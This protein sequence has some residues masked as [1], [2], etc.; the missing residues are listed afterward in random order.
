MSTARP[1]R[2]KE[3]TPAR[4]PLFESLETRLMMR[5]WGFSFLPNFVLPYTINGTQGN[6]YINVS[7]SNNAIL[8]PRM[9]VQINSSPAWIAFPA[10]GQAIQIHWQGRA[11]WIGRIVFCPATAKRLDLKGQ[12]REQ[13]DAR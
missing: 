8:G 6:D 10:V 7:Y 2:S 9:T 5:S 11:M 12:C 4:K 13:S 3:L 1:N